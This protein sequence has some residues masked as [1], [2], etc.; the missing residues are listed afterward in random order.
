MMFC[1]VYVPCWLV[2]VFLPFVVIVACAGLLFWCRTSPVM[3]YVYVVGVV[4][5]VL[6]L[7]VVGVIVVVVLFGW[8]C[9]MLRAPM[10]MF[11][12][13]SVCWKLSVPCVPVKFCAARVSVWCR[14]YPLNLRGVFSGLVLVRFRLSV[15]CSVGI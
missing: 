10:V 4:F 3:S 7:L 1:S 14:M 9:G 11:M 12:F 5:I 6:L 2:L 15:Y 8:K 13:G